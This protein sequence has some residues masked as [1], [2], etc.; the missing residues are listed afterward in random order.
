MD[1]RNNAFT[2][3]S[4]IGRLTVTSLLPTRY[5]AGWK[6]LLA[7]DC[8]ESVI[9]YECDLIGPKRRASCGCSKDEKD[10]RWSH[11]LY[12]IW[13]GMIARCH[14]ENDK[15][16]I[17]YGGRGIEVCTEWRQSPF[18]FYA[19]M[20]P[21]PD[22]HTI[23]RIDVNGHYKPGNV[24]WATASQQVCN[25]RCTKWIAKDG[26]S[27]APRQYWSLY[28]AQFVDYKTF[29]YRL[30]SGWD[31]NRASTPSTIPRRIRHVIR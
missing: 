11:P 18:T 9:S 31:I 10:G 17:N 19:Y 25:R 3:G 4:R 12:G 30:R 14:N 20:P 8:G 13:L 16:Y 22:G 6:Y 7:C 24:R 1:M 5:K 27:Y 2:V 21:R 15:D 29:M 28:V 23:D 26:V